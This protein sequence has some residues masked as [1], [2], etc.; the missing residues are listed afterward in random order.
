MLS[1]EAVRDLERQVGTPHVYTRPA[2]L[3]AYGYDAYG[4]SGM[5]RLAEAVVFPA[6]T[7][8]VSGVVAVCA[9]HGV[10]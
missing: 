8:E 9:A 5:R 6:S 4:A 10:A 7:E 1:R 3:A 2:D